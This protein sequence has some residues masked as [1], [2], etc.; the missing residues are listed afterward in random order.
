MSMITFPQTIGEPIVLEFKEGNCKRCNKVLHRYRLED[1][2]HECVYIIKEENKEKKKIEYL[3][4]LR[5][6]SIEKR[7]EL[8]EEW[9]YNHEQ[10]HPS[11]EWIMR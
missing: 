5:L 1:Y 6:N 9:I 7:I 4:K 3:E 8:I 10:N 2:C 11:K